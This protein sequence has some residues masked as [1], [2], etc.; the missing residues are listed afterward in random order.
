MSLA[1]LLKYIQAV[2]L[3]LPLIEQIVT[4]V[5]GLFA[6]VGSGEGAA[7]KQAVKE[8][9][10]ASLVGYGLSLPGETIDEVVDAVVAVKNQTGEFT[11]GLSRAPPESGV[12]SH[13]EP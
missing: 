3:L 6:K 4:M 13:S 5:E 1:N 11:H 10:K 8:I 9:A 12:S 7:K 2:T